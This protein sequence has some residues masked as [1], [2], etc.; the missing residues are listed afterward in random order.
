M[1]AVGFASLIA[2][3]NVANLLLARM[4]HRDAISRCARRSAPA[5]RASCDGS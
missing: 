2:C 4:A 5:T 3:A 1:G